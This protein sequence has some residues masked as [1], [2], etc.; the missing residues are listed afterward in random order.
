MRRRTVL[1]LL[2]ALASGGLAGWSALRLL[3]QGTNTA[4]GI[5]AENTTT[6][7][8][9]AARDLPVASLVGT[10]DVKLIEWPGGSVPLGYAQNIA[11]V[12][13]RGVLTPVTINEPLIEAKLADRSGGGGMP[14]VIEEG[15]RAVSVRVDGL[16]QV[17]GF[18]IQGTRVD[19]VLITTPPG[20]GEPIAKTVLQNMPVI[21]AGQAIQPDPEGK[22]V[23]VDILTFHVTP[24]VGE[25]LIL[26]STQGRIQM[27]LRNKLDM[28]EVRTQGARMANV[29]TG[30]TGGG[31]GGTRTAAPRPTP[32]APQPE[33]QAGQLEVYRGGEKNIIRFNRRGGE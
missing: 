13:G 14:I 23:V 19:I 11:D 4:V 31:G 21:A 15:M 25:K 10:E 27:A 33:A 9:V 5:T 32:T 2:L 7:I 24:E 20:S 18:V 12:V 6:K 3:E 29:L 8:V 30:A 28:K 22:P 17:A 26:A 16:A 1:I